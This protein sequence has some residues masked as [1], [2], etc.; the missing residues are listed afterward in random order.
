M[1][2]ADSCVY[3]GL[4]IILISIPAPHGLQN[5]GGLGGGGGGLGR[6]GS[7]ETEYTKPPLCV[8]VWGGGGY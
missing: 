6:Q 7:I 2:E 8:C 4:P 1:P 5:P 3:N